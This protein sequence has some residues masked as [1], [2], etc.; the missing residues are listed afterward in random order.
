MK[1]ESNSIDVLLFKLCYEINKQCIT[2]VKGIKTKELICPK[3]ILTNP[4]NNIITIPE[5]KLN[6]EYLKHELIFYFRKH[7]NGEFIRKYA[8]T[9]NDIIRL[10]GKINSTY[11]YIALKQKIKN[12]KTQFDWCLERLLEDKHSRQA[13]INF[14]Q[15]KHKIEGTHDFVC[16]L[17]VQYLIRNNKL[18]SIN[19]MRSN[20]L[21]WGFC[22]DVPFFT[23]LQQLLYLKLKEK[24][25]TLTLGEYIHIP[26][27]IHVYERHFNM[28]KEIINSNWKNWSLY[29]LPKTDH[30]FYQDVMNNDSKSDLMN[31][32]Y[33]KKA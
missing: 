9:W 16:T 20:D 23:I 13:V 32:I 21:I 26:S 27:S 28:I 19:Y 2:N 8:K 5:R 25:K 6:L 22:Y 3:I 18:I 7:K 17:D 33:Q 15:I 31:W 24:Y 30:M 29:S 1:I 10:D 11:G 14:N 12:N 4:L